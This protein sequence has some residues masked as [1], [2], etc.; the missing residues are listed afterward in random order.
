[1][2]KNYIFAL[3]KLNDYKWIYMILMDIYE[4]FNFRFCLPNEYFRK[5]SI[6]IESNNIYNGLR[7]ISYEKIR[8]EKKRKS[9]CSQEN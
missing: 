9:F 3:E 6:N 2:F 8:K 7:L 4:F 5:Y 1:M